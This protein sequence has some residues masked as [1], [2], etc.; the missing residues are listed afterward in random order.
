L[1]EP[2][3]F[4]LR[5]RGVTGA[6][7]SHCFR[8][9][10]SDEEE[11]GISVDWGVSYFDSGGEEGEEDE[12]E[13]E[14]TEKEEEGEE[15]E[16]EGTEGKETE[17]LTEEAEEE[18]AGEEIEGTEGK[19][20]EGLTEEAEEAGEE[21][22]GTEGKETEGLTEEAEE[23]E[24]GEE[25]GIEEGET[26]LEVA[27]SLGRRGEREKVRFIIAKLF[28]SGKIGDFFAEAGR[29]TGGESLILLMRLITD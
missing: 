14:V 20:I 17:G 29:E 25:I 12:A 5:I 15:I 9:P 24:E 18:E 16:I 10:A 1:E 7:A 13:A 4:F 28:G 2:L 3:F 27:F 22:E 19:E 21:I 26:E 11:E 8:L 6:Q 23:E